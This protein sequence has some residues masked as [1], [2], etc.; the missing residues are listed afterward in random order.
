MKK[1]LDTMANLWAEFRKDNDLDKL[2]NSVLSNAEFWGQD[3]TLKACFADEIKCYLRAIVAKDT[4]YPE[5]LD[6]FV[7]EELCL[8]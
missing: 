3:L 6:A 8:K 1:N 4:S 2:V 5:V 7:K